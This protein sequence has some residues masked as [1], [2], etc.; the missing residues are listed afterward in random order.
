MAI[1]ARQRIL[2]IGLDGLEISYAEQRMNAGQMPALAALRDKSATFLLD[3]GTAQR[4]GLAWEHVASGLSPKDAN[5]WSAVEFNPRTYQVWQ[6]GARFVPFLESMDINAVVFDHPYFDLDRTTKPQGIVGW[7]AHD[8]GTTLKARPKALLKEFQEKFGNYPSPDWIYCCPAYSIEQCEQ[9]GEALTRAVK[10]RTQA[11]L[12]L[13]S[14]KFPSSDLFFFVTG[15]LHS[16][17]EGLWHGVDPSHPLH[18]EPS[19]PAAAK[20]LLKVHQAVDQMLG[21]LMEAA[22]DMTVFAFSMGGMG[23]NQSDLQSM[24]LLPELLYR[25]TFNQPLLQV[26]K[27]WSTHPETVPQLAAFEDWHTNQSWFQG[28]SKRSNPW[29]ETLNSLISR[30][31]QVPAKISATRSR[32]L[33]SSLKWQPSTIYQDRWS[34]MKAFALPSFYDGRIR[35]NLLGREKKGTVLLQDYEQV[36]SELEVMIRECRDPRTG[37][38]VVA[39]VERPTIANPLALDSSGA[40]MTIV[41]KGTTTAFDHPKYG[42]IGPIPYRR[43][44]GHTGPHGVAYLSGKKLPPGFYGVR[45]SFDVVPT[46]ADL[47]NTPIQTHVSGESLL[48]NSLTLK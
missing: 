42:L 20:A 11:A 17:I 8:P 39:E 27:E 31:A 33:K 13:M 26:K 38:P 7:G 34:E 48:K 5:R 41:W 32:K 19:A 45:S 30:F 24:L 25:Y 18:N 40:D 46:L 16:A 1:K 12:W 35:I 47:L 44:G 4:T 9:M 21:E 28:I 29:I 36:C 43:T 37:E 2:M 3:H 22:Q 6:E 10:T 14:E 15:E 23:P